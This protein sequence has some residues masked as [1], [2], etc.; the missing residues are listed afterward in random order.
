[1]GLEINGVSAKTECALN[2]EVHRLI[3]K[4]AVELA[5]TAYK[6]NTLTNNVQ[7]NNRN[8]N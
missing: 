3:L 6:E 2:S 8:N 4:R 1:M 7:I 5:T